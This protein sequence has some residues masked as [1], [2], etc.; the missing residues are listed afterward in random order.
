M[1]FETSFVFTN[2]EQ[3][4][5][6]VWRK[7]QSILKKR[8]LDVGADRGALKSHLPG[9]AEYTTCGLEPHHDV[10]AD[11]E[12]PLPLPA[13]EY[14]CVLCLDVLEHV[15]RIHEL[16]DELCRISRRYVIVSLPNPWSSFLRN[17]FQGYYAKEQPTKFYGL[18][19]DP[20][21]DRHKW[22]FS[23]SEAKRFIT[24]RGVRNQFQ[25]AQIDEMGL[26][27]FRLR[28]YRRLL[29]LVVHRTVR[30]DDLVGETVWAVLEKNS[31]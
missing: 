28:V 31:D 9:D 14:D 15:D 17:L 26:K 19:T 13:N 6:Y 18:P 27:G 10:R 2:R 8:I 5:E 23:A 4:A 24:E 29:S 7:Y 22:F 1:K 11:L 21:K 30:P 25:V 16:F 20:P 3:K 12:E